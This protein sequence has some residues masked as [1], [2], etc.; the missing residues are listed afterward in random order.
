MFGYLP[1]RNG[2]RAP[3]PTLQHVP[4]YLARSLITKGA[5]TEPIRTITILSS[6]SRATSIHQGLVLVTVR[7]KDSAIV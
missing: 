2:V 5:F 4:R 1:N 7:F 6:A 3:V